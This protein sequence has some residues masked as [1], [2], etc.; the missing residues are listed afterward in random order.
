MSRRKRRQPKMMPQ[1][2]TVDYFN[3]IPHNVA[4]AMAD[5]AC[6]AGDL[7]QA[8]RMLQCAN[9]GGRVGAR[10]SLRTMNRMLDLQGKLGLVSVVPFLPPKP[11]KKF[12]TFFI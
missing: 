6:R 4:H 10:S 8:L 2:V 9:R 12:Q 7:A 5:D 11:C 3:T 1:P